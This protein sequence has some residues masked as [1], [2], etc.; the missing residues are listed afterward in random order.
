MSRESKTL[1]ID[2]ALPELCGALARETGAV[3]QAPPGAGKTTHVPLALLGEAWLAERGIVLLEP[4]R[5]AARA[6]AARMAELLGERVGQTVG[7]RVRM[8]SRISARTRIEV[9]TEGILTRR[10]QADPGLEGVGLVIFDE[11]HE[12]SLHADLALALCLDVQRGLREDLRLLVMSATLEATPVAELLGGVPVVTSAGRSHSVEV[13]YLD[14]DPQGDVSA[15]TAAAV[16][17]ALAEQPGDVLV[18]LP[19]GREIRLTHERLAES[20]VFRGVSVYPLHGDLPREQQD[21]AIQSDP[22]GRRKV[23]LA[24]SIA[25]TSLTIDGIGAVVDAGWSRVPRF[26]PRTGLTRLATVRV[27]RDAAEQRAGRAG[28]LGPGIAY[29]LWSEA[30]QHG[31]VARATPEILSADM[32]PLALE[33]GLWGVRHAESLAWLDPPPQGALAQARQLLQGLDALDGEGIATPAGRAMA[34]LGVHPR[35]AHMLLEGKALGCAGLACD[36]AALI[37]ERDLLSGQ[38]AR[39]CSLAE[40]LEPL[41]AYRVGGGAAARRHGADPAAC[42]RVEQAARQWRRLLGAD[43]EG[44]GGHVDQAG[45]LLALA[46]PDRIAM[47]RDP[48]AERYVLSS[49]RGVR[50]PAGDALMRH[51]Y[52]A[53]ASLDAGGTGEGTVWLAAPVSLEDLRAHLGGRI[54]RHEVVR[55]DGREQAVVAQQEE[56][57]GELVLGRRPLPRPAGEALCLA[58]LEGIRRQGLECLPWTHAARDWQARVLSLRRWLPEEGWPDVSDQRLAETLENWLAPHVEGMTRIEHLKR[59]DVLAVL[60]GLLDWKQRAALDQAAPTHIQVPSG[61]RLRLKYQPGEPPVLAVK[62]QE[63]FGLA[64]G[65]RVAAGRVSV[66]LHLLSPARRPIQVTQDLRSFWERTYPEVRK[67][68]KGRYPKHP[69]P[70]DP[71]SAVPTARTTRAG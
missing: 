61:S 63:M 18:F 30:M 23:V 34:A 24:T 55:W 71:W 16:Q 50:L 45:L 13:R 28:R 58:L 11:F 47:R 25:E 33:L 51:P 62:L 41:H 8:D 17:R 39:G 70:D 26:D 36:V 40:R 14:R 38:A 12:R 1:P 19:G 32:A 69:W 43:E 27:T 67:E 22:D 21:R 48:G 53:V 59:L 6:A 7:Y 56:R 4:R 66:I 65:P 20:P 60:Q 5:L 68:L 9:V 46:Y 54:Q 64:D 15:Y 52:L 10:L 29:R 31:L 37:V 49:G 42:Q 57:L 44:E 35:L 3:L 2:A